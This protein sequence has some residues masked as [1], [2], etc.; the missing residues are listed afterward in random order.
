MMHRAG[1]MVLLSVCMLMVQLFL[2]QVF[3]QE[4]PYT[5]RVLATNKT[6]TMEK[7]M[8]EAAE[9]GFI[10]SAAMG[11]E[12]AFGGDEAVVIMVKD[13]ARSAE[14]RR[15]YKL[16]ATSKTGTM[17]RE[18]QELADEGFEYKG[19]TVFKTTFG[20][21]EVCVIMERDMG[22]HSRRMQYKLLAT[23]KTSTMQKELREAGEAGY[24]L[25]GMTVG[26]TAFRGSEVV[27]ILQKELK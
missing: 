9:V 26:K 24:Y 15:V 21:Q 4:I 22:K 7:E 6:S 1:W 17:Q 2:P 25:V 13:D 23:S 27:S 5:Y 8:N 14:Q 19:Q 18:M 11:G 16:L 3:S 20:G 12:T 10:F